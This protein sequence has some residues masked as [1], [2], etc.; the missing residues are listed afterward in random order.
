MTGVINSL[1]IS[2]SPESQPIT[3]IGPRALFTLLTIVAISLAFAGMRLGWVR[4]ARR[5]NFLPKPESTVPADAKLA[6]PAVEARLAGTTIA[7][8]WLDRVN[9]YDLCTP[10]AVEV[11]TYDIG[12]F[13]TD[14][15]NFNLWIPQLRTSAIARGRGIAGDVVEPEGL[16]V[17]TWRL[18]DTDLDTGIRVQR[19]SDH[20][21]TYEAIRNVVIHM[22]D[23][24]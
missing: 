14:G 8:K 1:A 15:E 18:G 21:K 3:A 12:V 6:L 23:K 2:S 24:A 13:I 9:T 16:I 19:H 4:T 20:E 5:F 7:G 10:R 17:L 22:G 11:S